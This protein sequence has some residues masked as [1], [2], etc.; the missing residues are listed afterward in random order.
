MTASAPMP[1]AL[2]AQMAL[3]GAG[4]AAVINGVLNVRTV[5]D[6][7]NL[8]AYFALVFTGYKVTGMCH[9]ADCDCWVQAMMKLR[10]D[11]KLVPVEVQVPIASEGKRHG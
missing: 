2:S 1:A 7:P 11:I 6:G 5:S 10:P 9:D 8:S 3:S 4:Y